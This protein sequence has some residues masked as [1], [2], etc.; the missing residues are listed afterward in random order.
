MKRSPLALVWAD[1]IEG[2]RKS[3]LLSLHHRLLGK[4]ILEL[5]VEAARNLHPA[6]ILAAIDGGGGDEENSPSLPG[7]CFLT[8]QK[9]PGPLGAILSAEDA[10]SGNRTADLIVL[11]ARLSLL[12]ARS[13]R[14][15]LAAHR[16]SGNALTLAESLGPLPVQAFRVADLLE[17]LDTLKPVPRDGRGMDRLIE[18]MAERGRKIGTYRLRHPEESLSVRTPAGV[19]TAIMFL[20][21]RKISQL[22]SRGVIV[23]DPSTTWVDLDARIGKGTV[24]YP[25]VVIEGRTRIGTECRIYPFVHLIDAW[26]GGRVKILSSTVIEKSRIESDAQVGP[27]ARLRPDTLVRSRAK[28][29]NFV[30][31]KNTV[32]GKHSKAGH[33]S[34]LGDAVVGEGVNIGAGTITCNYDGFRKSTTRIDGGAFIGSGTELVAPVRIGRDAYIGAGSVIT[35]NVPPEALAVARG[36]QV[37]RPG[38]VRRRRKK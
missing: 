11:D 26:V 28:V 24:L 12:G 38:W 31:M 27:F 2:G 16:R 6:D 8:T 20:R 1:R 4:S 10:L 3:A 5:A 32:F 29:G 34:Y 30:E 36:R 19:S 35:K 22:E 13:L 25:S 7:V 18:R 21:E 37:E 14:S 23:L 9:T 17:A 33:L 15:L